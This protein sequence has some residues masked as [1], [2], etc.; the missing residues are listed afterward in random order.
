MSLKLKYEARIVII[1]LIIRVSQSYTV[2]LRAMDHQLHTGIVNLP[3]FTCLLP[4]RL[5]SGN[6][7]WDLLPRRR[8][9]L[10]LWLMIDCLCFLFWAV[11]HCLQAD[12]C[13][14]WHRFCIRLFSF[15]CPYLSFVFLDYYYE[16]FISTMLCLPLLW[17]LWSTVFVFVLFETLY[18]SYH[19]IPSLTLRA[20]LSAPPTRHWLAE[21]QVR[22]PSNLASPIIHSFKLVLKFA[23]CLHNGLLGL[24]IFWIIL[25]EAC[26]LD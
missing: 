3:R 7:A 5:Q 2:H 12:A 8:I 16:Y 4:I 11:L 25:T 18:Q 10:M 19:S 26:W 9:L 1:D 20:L 21:I 22:P 14:Y 23:W 6:M 15:P 24:S 13:P 17:S